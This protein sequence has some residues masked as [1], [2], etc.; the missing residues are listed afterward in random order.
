MK[1]GLGE[2][3]VGT[4]CSGKDRL[5]ALTEAASTSLTTDVGGLQPRPTD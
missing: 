3:S 2:I 5:E 4:F 1:V